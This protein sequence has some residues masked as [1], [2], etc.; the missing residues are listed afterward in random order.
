MIAG[1]VGS[2]KDT[3]ESLGQDARAFESE[4]TKYPDFEHLEAKGRKE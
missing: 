1:A 4:I 2:L 3:L